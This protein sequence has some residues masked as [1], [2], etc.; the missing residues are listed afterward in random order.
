MREEGRISPARTSRELQAGPQV[1][2]L[3]RARLEVR[4]ARGEPRQCW[5]RAEIP[6]A[7]GMGAG[8]RWGGGCGW[9]GPDPA[10]TRELAGVMD[11]WSRRKHTHDTHTTHRWEIS[12]TRRQSVHLAR[13]L[14]DFEG[15]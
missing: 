1:P 3:T 11:A 10:E 12:H 9:L 4:W 2:V 8:G 7:G 15:K 5:G 14:T 6:E 13:L